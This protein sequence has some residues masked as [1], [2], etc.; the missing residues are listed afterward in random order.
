[1]NV[2][3]NYIESRFIDEMQAKKTQQLRESVDLLCFC[4]LYYVVIKKDGEW[5]KKFMKT[6]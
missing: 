1:M 6:L 4:Y 2:V 3:K 5:Q